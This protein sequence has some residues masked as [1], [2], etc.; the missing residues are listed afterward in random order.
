MLTKEECRESLSDL[1]NVLCSRLNEE[2]QDYRQDFERLGELI[3]EHF[4]KNTLI[5]CEKCGKEIPYVLVEMFNR[6]GSDSF[7]DYS[8]K[9]VGDCITIVTDSNWCGYELSE[10]DM[11][12][13]ILCPHCHDYPFE[14]EEIHV[15]DE[16]EIVMFPRK[17][18]QE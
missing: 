3:R 5:K 16:V 13:T 14:L 10:E 1:Y 2:M 18:V 9:R 8:Y 11:K 7:L 17:E 4:D 12:G 15:F 6:D